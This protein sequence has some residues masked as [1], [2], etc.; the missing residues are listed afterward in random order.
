M[1]NFNLTNERKKYFDEKYLKRY[2]QQRLRGNWSEYRNKESTRFEKVKKTFPVLGEK[3][4]WREVESGYNLNL[5]ESRGIGI[6]EDTTIDSILEEANNIMNI[7]NIQESD[8]IRFNEL[9]NILN[10]IKIEK[11]I[12]NMLEIGFRIP[13]IQHFFEKSMN[14]KTFGVDINEFNC[15][16]FSELGYNTRVFDMN[17]D[18]NL[19]DLFDTRF[20]IVC[21]YHVIEHLENPFEAVRKI[22]KA[23]EPG[24]IFH[25]EIPIEEDRPQLEYGHLFGFMP[26]ELGK[27]LKEVGFDIIYG[28]NNTHTGGTWI[29]RYTAI[30]GGEDD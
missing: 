6:N 26:E 25:V 17:H 5:Q 18:E 14:I 12:K 20:N 1:T 10:Q 2:R 19:E 28:T 22:Y 24:G 9:I 23:M 8:A 27:I 11:E 16:L 15:E 21:C 7:N 4:V 29:E 13:K 3:I 30:K